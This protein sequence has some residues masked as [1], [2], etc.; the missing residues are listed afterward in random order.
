MMQLNQIHASA[1]KFQ[2]FWKYNR[3]I[4]VK[5]LGKAYLCSLFEDDI[6]GNI[7]KLHMDLIK[8]KLHIK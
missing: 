3:E 7:K 2:E 5:N 8:E 4:D 1:P 6:L